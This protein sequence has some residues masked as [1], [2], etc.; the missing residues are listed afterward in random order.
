MSQAGKVLRIPADVA[1]LARVRAF[2]RQQAEDSGAQREEIDDLVTA[3]DESVTNVIVHGYSGRA[4][5]VEV[6]M[7]VDGPVIVVRLRDEARPFDPTTAPSPDISLPLERRPPGGLG[8]FLTRELA[9]S[10]DYRQTATGNE[11]TM[12]KHI[13]KKGDPTC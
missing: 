9:D 12:V 6:A 7:N 4:G 1:E 11:L 8:I 3:V 5:S 13:Q 2:V 10:V